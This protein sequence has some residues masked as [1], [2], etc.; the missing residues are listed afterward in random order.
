[1]ATS[2]GKSVPYGEVPRPC[3]GAGRSAPAPDPE[4]VCRLLQRTE[5][6]P[7]P[8]RRHPAIAQF[9]VSAPSHQAR[10]SV[11]CTINTVESKLRHTPVYGMVMSPGSRPPARSG[12]CRCQLIPCPSLGFSC[13]V[14][15]PFL[16][17]LRHRSLPVAGRIIFIKDH[18]M[19]VRGALEIGKPLGWHLLQNE[20]FVPAKKAIEV[21]KFEDRVLT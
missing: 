5:N 21:A 4:H 15:S 18:P 9:S 3:R 12:Q 20:H 8:D 14:E 10:S 1:M 13:E 16:E 7:I 17:P 2:N 19:E 11:A 6:P